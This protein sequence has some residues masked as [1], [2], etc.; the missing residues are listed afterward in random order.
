M[1]PTCPTDLQKTIE[2][3]EQLLQPTQGGARRPRQRSLRRRGG[4]SGIKLLKR[5]HEF[6]K[7]KMH[8]CRSPKIIPTKDSSQQTI[9]NPVYTQHLIRNL[10]WD[11]DAN[12]SQTLEPTIVSTNSKDIEAE[13][14]LTK[15][16]QVIAPMLKGIPLTSFMQTNSNV[17]KTLLEYANMPPEK[18]NGEI[19]QTYITAIQRQL[20]ILDD[21]LHY[22]L[23]GNTLSRGLYFYFL[24]VNFTENVFMIISKV[25]ISLWYNSYGDSIASAK[26]LDE[27]TKQL[28]TKLKNNADIPHALNITMELKNAFDQFK[29]SVFKKQD[30]FKLY[31]NV[32]NKLEAQELPE[33][34]DIIISNIIAS[35]IEDDSDQIKIKRMKLHERMGIKPQPPISGGSKS[36]SST[37]PK[38][39]DERIIYNGRNR[40]VYK[41]SRK[42]SAKFILIKGN[43]VK[44]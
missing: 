16:L 18:N 25:E 15:V 12:P 38:K 42:N 9:I 39:T 33:N 28:E 14:S 20:A 6:L 3:Y 21:N 8:I 37:I 29:A 36:K 11:V 19:L 1:D 44:I 40:I 32:A 5:I 27:L 26:T 23:P 30:A 22:S 41:T 2:I 7:A 24:Q 4:G 13:N 10:N 17:A 43:L 35:I 31:M 34:F